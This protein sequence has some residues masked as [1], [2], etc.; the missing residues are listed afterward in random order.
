MVFFV[1]IHSICNNVKKICVNQND[2]FFNS[3][4]EHGENNL[5]KV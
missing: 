1:V 2:L 4:L 5:Y 3:L